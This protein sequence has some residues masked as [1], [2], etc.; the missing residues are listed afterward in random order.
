V[1]GSHSR[2]QRGCIHTREFRR[3]AEAFDLPVGP[4]QSCQKVLPLALPQFAFRENFRRVV[5]W[6]IRSGMY[7][8]WSFTDRQIE[9]KYSAPR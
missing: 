9:F 8:G 7:Y 5:V 6:A 2:Y 3:T 4:V 1:H